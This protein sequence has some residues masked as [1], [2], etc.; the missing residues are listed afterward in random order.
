MTIEMMQLS[1]TLY[2]MG[3]TARSTHSNFGYAET[4]YNPKPLSVIQINERG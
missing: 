1:A 4:S 2:N 3:Y